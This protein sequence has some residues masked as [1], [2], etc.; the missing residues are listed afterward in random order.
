MYRGGGG[1][2]TVHPN[3]EHQVSAVYQG[4]YTSNTREQLDGWPGVNFQPEILFCSPL[5]SQIILVY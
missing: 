3:Y 4:L 5:K 1:G 2:V